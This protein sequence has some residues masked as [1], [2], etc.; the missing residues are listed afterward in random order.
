MKTDVKMNCPKCGNSINVDEMLVAQFNLSIKTDLEAELVKRESEL[1]LRKTEFFEMSQQLEKEKEDVASIVIARVKEL[2]R[3]KEDALKESIRTEV[4]E[5]KSLQLQEL[6]NELIKKSAQLQQFNYTKAKLET[7]QREAE[8]AETR[9]TLE[10]EKELTERLEQARVSIKEQAQ[11]ESFL[12]LKE[13]EKVIEDLKNKLDEAKRRAEQGSMQLQGEIQELEIIELLSEFHPFDEITQSKKG[14][15]AADILQ[16][17][18]T[19]NGAECGKIYYESKRTKSWSNDWITKFKQDNIS[20]KADILVLVTN[21]LPKN[22]ERYGIV[23]N[24]WVCSFNDVKELSLVLRYGLLKLQSVAITQQGKES[25]ME[26]LYNYL[27]SEEFKNCFESILSGFKIL[28]D[29]H[30]SEILKM[31]RLWKE[32]EKVLEQVL[33]NTVEFYGSIRGIAGAA[34]PEVKMLEFLPQAS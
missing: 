23:D 33:S 29:S 31:K 18:K 6:E 21:A 25:K 16:V 7:L 8:E 17:V 24:V 27:T 1:N 3:A 15:N 19:Q 34:I 5:E 11:Q 10:K 30:Q 20:T 28:S 32:R 4:N 26:L 22:I 12:K 14:A 2:L 13:R 9:I